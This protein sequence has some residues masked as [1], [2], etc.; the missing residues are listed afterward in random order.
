[1]TMTDTRRAELE[2]RLLKER[3]RVLQRLERHDESIATSDEDGDLTTYPLHLAD[4]GTDT[5]EQEKDLMLRSKEG[6]HL[7]LIDSALRKLYREPEQFGVC[8]NCGEPI[9]DERLDLVPWTRYCLKCVESG[10]TPAAD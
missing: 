10:A 4:E 8:E 7:Q 5:M 2:Q 3:D 1:M 6:D 9:P